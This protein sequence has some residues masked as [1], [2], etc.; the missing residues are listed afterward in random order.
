MNPIRTLR[1]TT[2][3]FIPKYFVAARKFFRIKMQFVQRCHIKEST[4][5]GYIVEV[6]VPFA[7]SEWDSCPA[8]H[9]LLPKGGT[10][11]PTWDGLYHLSRIEVWVNCL[12]TNQVFQMPRRLWASVGLCLWKGYSF[13]CLM[14]VYSISTKIT[15]SVGSSSFVCGTDV[16]ELESRLR[17]STCWLF[18]CDVILVKSHTNAQ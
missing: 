11:F 10:N 12:P 9:W 1:L 18:T 13:E 7:V 4:S 3:Y 14:I 17:R 5:C 2:F 15:W 8:R 16:V 6:Q